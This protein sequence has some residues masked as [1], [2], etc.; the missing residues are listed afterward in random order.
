MIDCMAMA[1]GHVPTRQGTHRDKHGVTHATNQHPSYGAWQAMICSI[2]GDG[3]INLVPWVLT[4]E[5]EDCD[6]RG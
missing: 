4:K 1:R 5:K 2:R 3:R 6:E